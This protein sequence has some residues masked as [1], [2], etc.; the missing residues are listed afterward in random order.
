MRG[1]VAR[2]G[3]TARTIDRAFG[4]QWSLFVD[5]FGRPPDFLDGHQHVHLFPAMRDALFRLID[6]TKFKGWVRQCRTDARRRSRDRIVLDPLSRTFMRAAK[7]RGIMF[8][9]GF[10]GLRAFHRSEDLRGLWSGDLEAMGSG[11]LLMVHPGGAGSPAGA[12]A[13][14]A[15]RGDE[16]ALLQAGR[17][18]EIL[19]AQGWILCHAV[20]GADAPKRAR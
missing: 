10:G 19:C 7:R 18:D 9:P 6:D 5:A 11:G 2:G 4:H 17:L 14:D 1:V 3:A 8:N 12:D 13:I 16:A 15:C 20:P